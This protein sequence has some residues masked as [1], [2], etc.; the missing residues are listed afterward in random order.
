MTA[1]LVSVRSC[2]EAETALRGGAALIDVKE[3]SRGAMGRADIEII[4]AIVHQVDRRTPVSA[5][6]GELLVQQQPFAPPR[7]LTFA[8]WGLYGANLYGWQKALLRLR[9]SYSCCVVPCAYAEADSIHSPT[10]EEVAIFAATHRFPVLLVDTFHKNDQTLLDYLQPEQ[11]ARIAERCRDGGVQLA[12]AGSLNITAIQRLLPLRPTW[13]A[14]RGAACEGGRHG[15]VQE[16]RVRDL[17]RCIQN[18]S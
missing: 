1:L 15:R 9:E 12:L 11:L 18:N 2:E 7:Q 16:Y 13:F 5:A 4:E 3:P 8:K 10:P 17:V 14:V 6:M